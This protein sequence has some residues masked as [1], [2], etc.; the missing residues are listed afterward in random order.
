MADHT[1]AATL[2]E[3]TQPPRNPLA[4][5]RCNPGEVR[6]VTLQCNVP[7]RVDRW[8][9]AQ[10]AAE[11]CAVV[12]EECAQPAFQT[13]VPGAPP[14]VVDSGLPLVMVVYAIGALLGLLP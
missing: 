13:Q 9:S 3:S 2:A 8:G 12:R 14:Q 5:F 1:V 6:Q 11:L 4:P 7:E 10:S